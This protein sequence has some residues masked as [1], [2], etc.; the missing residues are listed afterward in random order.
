LRTRN[1]LTIAELLIGVII[2]TV[3]VSTDEPKERD[4][5]EELVGEWEIPKTKVTV[6]RYVKGLTFEFFPDSA[7]MYLKINPDKSVSGTIGMS[8]IQN[9]ILERKG[10]QKI[11]C[12][13]GKIFPGDPLENKQV[14]FWLQGPYGDGMKAELRYTENNS[15]FPMAGVTLYRVYD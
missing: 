9:G 3:I 13:V 10:G 5:P 15:K 1:L 8:E 14:S 11:N 12:S 2:V 6:R 4:A 7:S